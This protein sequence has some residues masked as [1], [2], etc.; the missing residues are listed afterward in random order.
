[1]N[2][3]E[4]K[5]GVMKKLMEVTKPSLLERIDKLL[6]DEM[7]VG[8]TV[9]GEPLTKELYNSRLQEAEHQLKIGEYLS[10]EELEKESGNW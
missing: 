3:Q 8:Y 9:D 6:D 4:T 10:Q 7:V 1:M 2:L 5:L